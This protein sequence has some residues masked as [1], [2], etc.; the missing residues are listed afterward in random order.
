MTQFGSDPRDCCSSA[1]QDEHR[2]VLGLRDCLCHFKG[3]ALDWAMWRPGNHS[4][5]IVD[6][7]SDHSKM[8]KRAKHKCLHPRHTKTWLHNNQLERKV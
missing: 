1:P 8:P 4:W 6:P 2:D 7:G 5:R 3:Q